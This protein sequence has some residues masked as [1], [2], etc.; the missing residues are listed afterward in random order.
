[1]AIKFCLSI[2]V[3]HRLTV[4]PMASM[5]TTPMRT[6]A[7]VKILTKQKGRKTK[8]PTASDQSRSGLSQHFTF[9][10]PTKTRS[11]DGV[12]QCSYYDMDG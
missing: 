4:G 12:F 6:R 8:R 10:R 2:S 1:M 9:I 7:M 11:P 5:I 3:S